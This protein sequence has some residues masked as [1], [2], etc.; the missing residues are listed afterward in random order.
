[1]G[2]DTRPASQSKPPIQQKKETPPEDNGKQPTSSEFFSPKF[3]GTWAPADLHILIYEGKITSSEFVLLQIIDSLVEAR[4]DGCWAS[5][6]YLAAR[7]HKSE[8]YV[9]KMIKKLKRLGLVE[10]AGWKK[11]GGKEYRMLETAWSRI[12]PKQEGGTGIA[13]YTP[14]G[15]T[16][17]PGYTYRVPTKVGTNKKIQEKRPATAGPPSLEPS[18]PQNGFAADDA[19]N[20]PFVPDG[21]KLM[22]ALRNHKRQ[23]LGSVKGWAKQLRLLKQQDQQDY[24]ACLD[25]YCLHCGKE[26]QALLG[27]PSIG[28][29]NQFRR[30]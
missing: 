15:G 3:R 23:V 17:I 19:K 9:K 26:D 18:P 28:S 8:I 16:G 25:W 2:K 10:F 29:A 22:K 20:T 27:L 13:G 1:M 7:M 30:H 11:A 6:A 24:L 5:N 14:E 4:G 12:Q 21:R